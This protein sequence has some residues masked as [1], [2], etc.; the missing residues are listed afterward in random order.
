MKRR[1]P[2]ARLRRGRRRGMRAAAGLRGS[3]TARAPRPH[4]REPGHDR[5]RPGTA[6]VRGAAVAG[7]RRREETLV[8]AFEVGRIYNG[9]SSAIGFAPLERRRQGL[10]GR[11][12]AADRRR[13]GRPR[14]AA[15]TSGAAPT[16][17]PRYDESHRLWLISST[18]LG[19]TGPTR[20]G[21]SSTA[22]RTARSGP[23]RSSRTRRRTGDAP[24]NGSLACD[25]STGERR[26]RHVLHRLHQHGVDARRTS[27]SSSKSTDGGATWS[28]PVG[29]P[30]ASVGTG[31]VTLVQ[32][33][34]PGAA[35]GSTCGRVVVAYVER[36]DAST[37]SPRATAAPR[38]RLTRVVTSTQAAQH[39]V[40]QGV[41]TSLVVVRLGRRR[42]RALP[43]LAD[44]ELPHRADDA[45][46]GCER[47]RH[48]HQGRERHRHG[49]RATRSRSTRPARTP[50][51]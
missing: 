48:E 6:P 35:A 41:R 39:T 51:R 50:R 47:G 18:G 28:A 15:G 29:T 49:R 4:A 36:N 7:S 27:S 9:G 17:P 8:G 16:R 19:S 24:Q 3:R 33:P 22:R 23:R 5:R 43:R 21:C 14:R 1:A 26:L 38:G 31:A 11:A 25:N 46:G 20:S 40:A 34:P 37:T 42:R 45:L 32:P 44:A 13:Q 10:A 12:R 2:E 30:D